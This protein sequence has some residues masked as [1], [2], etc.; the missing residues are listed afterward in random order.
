MILITL[1]ALYDLHAHKTV[2]KINILYV[3]SKGVLKGQGHYWLLDPLN[4]F[5]T[6]SISHT[7][8]FTELAVNVMLVM[9]EVIWY[10]GFE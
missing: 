3:H 10:W 2:I 7:L 1:M 4:Q 6:H 8:N 5:H 9:F